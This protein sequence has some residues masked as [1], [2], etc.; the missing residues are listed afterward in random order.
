MKSF[1]AYDT[2]VEEALRGVVKPFC[3]KLRVKA[4]WGIIISISPFAQ[5]TPMW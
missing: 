4:F 2:L 5:Q 1:I 3:V